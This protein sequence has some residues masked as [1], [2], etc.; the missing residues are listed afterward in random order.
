M[1]V[2]KLLLSGLLVASGLILG[3][4][5]LHARFAPEWEV[6]ASAVT[7]RDGR[8]LQV[9]AHPEQVPGAMDEVP[10]NWAPRLV[11]TDPKPSA[12]AETEAAKAK[13]RLADKKQAEKRPKPEKT[14][15]E[16]QTMF[17]WLTGLL[18]K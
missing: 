1:S 9:H 18:S 4:F 7:G 6:Q 2:A 15:Q 8:P 11:K 14:K 13:K 3:A 12:A 10:N 5:T 17:S 16:E